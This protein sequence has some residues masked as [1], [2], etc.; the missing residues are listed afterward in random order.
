METFT[1]VFHYNFHFLGRSI[2]VERE[3]EFPLREEIDEITYEIIDK[4]NL[5]DSLFEDINEKLHDFIADEE[6][7]CYLDLYD[8]AK[9]E[10]DDFSSYWTNLYSMQ[11][12]NFSSS[13]PSYQKTIEFTERFNELLSASRQNELIRMICFFKQDID[14][15]Y[16]RRSVLMT[17]EK[18]AYLAMDR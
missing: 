16:K 13:M 1:S 2:F 5:L 7:N 18:A 12:S 10:D 15:C 6:K 17:I 8:S 9:E 11:W 14:E 4:H 3:I